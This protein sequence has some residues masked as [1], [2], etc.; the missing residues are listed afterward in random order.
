MYFPR[1]QHEKEPRGRFNP[2][3]LDWLPGMVQM[4]TLPPA[5]VATY[6]QHF[7][8]VHYNNMTDGPATLPCFPDLFRDW[9]HG[10]VMFPPFP[11][12]GGPSDGAYYPTGPQHPQLCPQSAEGWMEA[13]QRYY[14]YF[15]PFWCAYQRFLRDCYT[16]P[17][18]N[19][20]Y[21]AVPTSHQTQPPAVATADIATF[22]RE[23]T[24]WTQNWGCD[25]QHKENTVS[26]KCDSCVKLAAP[27]HAGGEVLPG[28]CETTAGEWREISSLA[29]SS[30][31]LCGDTG[32]RYTAC[33]FF[34]GKT[35]C[36][37]HIADSYIY[38]MHHKNWVEKATLLDVCSFVHVAVG[39]LPKNL[40]LYIGD[41]VLDVT[42]Y[43][44]DARCCDLDLLPGAVVGVATRH[45]A[46][47]EMESK[48]PAEQF[49]EPRVEDQCLK[50][51]PISKASAS[52]TSLHTSETQ[53]GLLGRN[54]S[55]EG[56]N[57]ESPGVDDI[58]ADRRKADAVRQRQSPVA[59]PYLGTTDGDLNSTQTRAQ[60]QTA[61]IPTCDRPEPQG[62]LEGKACDEI[63]SHND[64]VDSAQG[65]EVSDAPVESNGKT[66]SDGR[67]RRTVHVRF[68]PVSMA[69]SDIR[70]LLWSC[71][72][73]Y[74]VRL[75][76]PKTTPNPDKM[77][78][79]CFVEYAE[80]QA[81][82]KM[83]EMHGHRIAASFHLAVEIS[84]HAILGGYVTDRDV[85]TGKPCTFG[86]TD[87][88][89]WAIEQRHKRPGAGSA[90]SGNGECAE[91]GGYEGEGKGGRRC[92]R[93]GRKHRGRARQSTPTSGET[94][95]GLGEAG[96]QCTGG[97]YSLQ[98]VAEDSKRKS[99][100]GSHRIT[101]AKSGNG[102][103]G[104]VGELPQTTLANS[105]LSTKPIQS[106]VSTPREVVGHI[107]VTA[108]E[109]K[110]LEHLRNATISYLRCPSK[111][112]FYEVLTVL[113]DVKLCSPSPL[114]CLHLTKAEVALLF[115][116]RS[117]GFV[118]A[119]A[120]AANGA[121]RAGEEL[122]HLMARDA[123]SQDHIGASWSSFFTASHPSLCGHWKN[124]RDM[125]YGDEEE[126][127]EGSR[128]TKSDGGTA[129]ASYPRVGRVLC[130]VESLLHIALLCDSLLMHELEKDCEGKFVMRNIDADSPGVG[131]V[132]WKLVCCIRRLLQ[133]LR[134]FATE[135][136]GSGREDRTV[137]SPRWLTTVARVLV[138]LPSEAEWH[139]G[140]LLDAFVPCASDLPVAILEDLAGIRL[141]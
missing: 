28:D 56:D 31:L 41:H 116:H 69:F 52:S 60:Q 4:A 74:K 46:V 81:A 137:L 135:S 35:L 129:T 119:A 102:T 27:T 8:S 118:E 55:R 75:V 124:W 101:D 113:E 61:S 140:N 13:E 84:K 40:L 132:M 23:G 109:S 43:E 32:H 117:S 65:E 136:D 100:R 123:S 20:L 82:L 37:V 133:R 34:D 63:E 104:A 139:V 21:S 45:E 92:R 64:I 79:V 16:R 22:T 112:S 2:Q 19:D 94:P 128:N 62:G 87:T 44:T 18:T 103:T 88:E 107:S 53:E 130:F 105:D 115:L 106:T 91:E 51:S 125:V 26:N 47:P 97:P 126:S 86:L 15:H 38:A 134:A 99:C 95:N 49:S 121:V 131:K 72:E 17:V 70:A 68:I 54:E 111:R 1:H 66:E 42:S 12:A 6:P 11:F 122:S 96:K 5:P 108:E 39:I 29:L 83:L 30:C 9:L 50:V 67:R 25:A 110:L 89:R 90:G 114:C 3:A 71:G 33:R 76:K 77:F 10:G 59:A 127:G 138:L 73:V 85:G 98:I 141:F 14:K 7:P 78:Y 57:N 48:G 58:E 80:E 36:L 24:P 120:T 93:G